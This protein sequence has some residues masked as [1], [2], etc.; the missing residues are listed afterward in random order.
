MR[1]TLLRLMANEIVGRCTMAVALI[2]CRT[3]LTVVFD[4]F[5]LTQTTYLTIEGIYPAVDG[6]PIV[7]WP[8]DCPLEYSLEV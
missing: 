7:V 6:S 3:R 8:C 4:F 5:F 1:G 2:V